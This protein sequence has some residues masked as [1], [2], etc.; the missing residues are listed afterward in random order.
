MFGERPYIWA[1]FPDNFDLLRAYLGSWGGKSARK[2]AKNAVAA[3]MIY[4]W[5]RS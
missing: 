4:W 1:L 5:K 2:G 3:D